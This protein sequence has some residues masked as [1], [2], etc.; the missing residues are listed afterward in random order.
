MQ[1]RFCVPFT[2]SLQKPQFLTLHGV[3]LGYSG[4]ANASV[5]HHHRVLTLPVDVF[6]QQ[7]VRFAYRTVLRQFHHSLRSLDNCLSLLRSVP[8]LPGKIKTD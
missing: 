6:H 3:E 5:E 1:Q 4:R 2:Q 7:E 8:A